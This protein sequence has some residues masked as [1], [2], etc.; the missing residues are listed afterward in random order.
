MLKNT[1]MMLQKIGILL[2]LIG[3]FVSFSYAMPN[4]NRLG[5]RSILYA[6]P[7]EDL[8]T[9][10]EKELRWERRIERRFAKLTKKIHK[11]MKSNPDYDVRWLGVPLVLL[12]MASLAFLGG[13][14]IVIIFSQAFPEEGDGWIFPVCFG[15]GL[16]TIGL[17]VWLWTRYVDA[18]RTQK[19]RKKFKA[20]E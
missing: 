17:N 11:R 13:L 10:T 12:S 16:L 6:N 2:L 8:A 5:E 20:T 9:N 1:W 4:V 14:M 19:R 7:A 3:N 15:L 18:C